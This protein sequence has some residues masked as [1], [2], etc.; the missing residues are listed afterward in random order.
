MNAV[1]DIEAINLRTGN[2]L[3]RVS[4]NG[5]FRLRSI[6][7]PFDGIEGLHSID[8]ADLIEYERAMDEAIPEIIAAVRRR[9]RLAHEA[10]Q[11]WLG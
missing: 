8:P 1:G 11:R 6:P 3:Q 5:E 7:H 2:K 9:E 4:G 10:R